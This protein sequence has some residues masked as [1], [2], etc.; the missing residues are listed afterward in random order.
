MHWVNFM[1]CSLKSASNSNS[2]PNTGAETGSDSEPAV[3]AD[4]LAASSWLAELAVNGDSTRSH[5]SFAMQ[6]ALV[7]GFYVFLVFLQL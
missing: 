7:L 4:S 6:Y 3:Q 2:S 5:P 1:D